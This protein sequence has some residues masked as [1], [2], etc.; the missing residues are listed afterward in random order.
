MQKRW[1]LVAVLIIFAMLAGTVAVIVPNSSQAQD[2]DAEF[3]Y[4][5]DTDAPPFPDDVDWL[6]T[7]EPLTWEAL[8]GKIVILDFWTYGCINCIHVIPDL[9]A[10]EEEYADSLVVI[11]VHSAKF[12]NEG[13]T[14][15]IRQVVQRYGVTHPVINDSDFKVWST[16]GV[17]AWPTLVLI[18]PNGRI[19]GGRS[20][21]GVY[22]VFEPILRVMD[23]EY[24]AAGLINTSPV[25]A[26]QAEVTPRDEVLLNYPGKVLA[27]VAGNRLIVS[28]SSNHRVIVSTLDTFEN[29]QVIGTGKRGFT[30]GD[31][32]TAQF[33]TPQGLAIDGDTL[34]VADTNNHAI[35]TIDLANGTVTTLAGTGKQAST[36]P[37]A[38]GTAPVVELSSPWDVTLHD[39]VL[40]I[41]MA[42]PH[43]LWRIDLASGTVE[44][45]AGSGRENIIDGILGD[46]QLAQPS[47][48]DTDGERLFFA[49]AESS[50]IRTASIDPEGEV[51]TIVGTGLFDFGDADGTGDDVLLQHAL[52]VTVSEDG[53]LYITD[54][55]NNK[56]KVIDPTTRESKTF[57]GST[58]AGL[59]D[60]DLADARFYEPGGL[61]YAN[62]KL[63]I[64]DTNNHAIRIIDL[65]E[66][67]VSTV[68]Y[69]DTTALVMP[70]NTTSDNP[71]TP[72]TTYDFS[73]GENVIEYTMVTVAPGEGAIVFD[74]NLPDGYKLND[75]A[76]FTAISNSD[77]IVAIGDDYLDYRQ[78][79]PELPVRIPATFTEGQTEFSTD[80]TIYWCEGVNYTLCF[81]DNVTLNVS[82]MVADSA[83][84]QDVVLEYDL[85]PPI[86]E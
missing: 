53:L 49:D 23:E 62:G 27:D 38:S 59:V 6:N 9:H 15:N 29:V 18:D 13:E 19:V 32:A 24:F 46:A 66:G 5:G 2:G 69:A 86:L 64:A 55:Y 79:L 52:G 71:L 45:H 34:Y 56:I 16:Y 33:D 25:A 40:Y 10:L 41:A 82:V 8:R 28:D 42:G 76:P 48:I 47:G 60:G 61:D 43:Q 85:V 54:T 72:V 37:P 75:S 50:S 21:E 17:Q 78:V 68:Q 31:F 77:E 83:E 73:G 80:L 51:T 30:D 3:T 84:D 39:G 67:T 20:G 81:V 74:V 65:A 11:G 1:L 35:R 4:E 63:Y 14:D 26:I 58:E 36:Y 44:A 22:E 12:A 57:A 70:E 7:T